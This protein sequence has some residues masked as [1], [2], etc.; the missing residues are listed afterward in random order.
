MSIEAWATRWH[1]PPAALAELKA[2]MGRHDDAVTA[3]S[4]VSEAAI[5]QQTRLEACRHG[6][7]LWRNNN[8]ACMSED[9]RLIRYGLCNDSAAMN[10][11]LKSSDLIGITPHIVT[12]QDVGATLGI[13][14]SIEIKR[15]G[16]VFKGTER[17]WAQFN[18]MELIKSLGGRAQFATSPGEVYSNGR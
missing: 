8:G 13:F 5:Q 16:W 10:K 15:P 6:D 11:K 4:G 12:V 2:T 9:G 14:T 3:V 1:I 18:W 17:E 7:R